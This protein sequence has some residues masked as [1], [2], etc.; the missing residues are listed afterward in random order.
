MSLKEKIMGKLLSKSNRYNFYKNYYEINK[1]ENENLNKKLDATIKELH[2]NNSKLNKKMD[3]LDK[4]VSNHAQFL[5]NHLNEILDLEYNSKWHF[6]YIEEKMINIE[7]NIIKNNNTFNNILSNTNEIRYAEV[8]NNTIANSE[9]LKNKNFSLNKGAS[10][11]S[12]MYILYRILDETKPQKILEFGLGQTS[13]LTTEYVNHFENT[14][15]KIIEDDSTW[16]ENFSK[17]LDLKEN[18]EI[19]QCDTEIFTFDETENLRYANLNKII[20]D[21]KFNLI[22]IDGPT[23]FIGT[24]SKDNLLKYPRTNIWNLI[25]ND[26]LAENFTIVLDDYDREGEQNTGSRILELLNEK[27]IDYKTYTYHGLKNQLLVCS[28]ET[29]FL[30]WL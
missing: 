12:F 5:N 11:Y 17:K 22:I 9:W 26:N 20:K 16:I 18:S 10:N 24:Y 13:T 21:E 29:S 14:S 30:T 19:I 27:N 1:K 15:L 6:K 23:G 7:D 28:K 25:E 2:K 3:K 4:H 8:F